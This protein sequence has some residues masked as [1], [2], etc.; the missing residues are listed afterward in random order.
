VVKPNPCFL[1]GVAA[2]LLG[3]AYDADDE[4]RRDDALALIEDAATAAEAS[5]AWAISRH[6]EEARTRFGASER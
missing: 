2:N 6:I 3:L 5:G 4:G 1:P